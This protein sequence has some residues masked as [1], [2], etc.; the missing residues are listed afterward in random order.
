MRHLRCLLLGHQL[1][2]VLSVSGVEGPALHSLWQRPVKRA[3][4]L[5]AHVYQHAHCRL[6]PRRQRGK[7]CSGELHVHDRELR[8]LE[9]EAG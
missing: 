6:L 3:V 4:E 8:L 5:A 7:R 2:P 1:G 9:R